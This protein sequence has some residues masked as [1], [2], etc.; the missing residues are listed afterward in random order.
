M[1]ELD[2][3]IHANVFGKVT[4]VGKDAEVVLEESYFEKMAP[5]VQRF[6]LE[7][8]RDIWFTKCYGKSITFKTWNGSIVAKF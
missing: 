4:V 1:D 8:V 2:E 6:T 5:D 7:Q 3:K